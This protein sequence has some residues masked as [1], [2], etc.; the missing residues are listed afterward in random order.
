MRAT[1]RRQ[2]YLDDLVEH[3]L[4]RTN[5]VAHLVHYMSLHG[6]NH[7]VMRRGRRTRG[8]YAADFS[9]LDARVPA[10]SFSN[11]LSFL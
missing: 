11:T 3:V 6:A 8:P 4:I 9:T 2:H 5:G 7:P 1:E 10:Q